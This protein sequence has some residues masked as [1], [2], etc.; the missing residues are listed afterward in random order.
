MKI[1]SKGKID[2]ENDKRVAFTLAEQAVIKK[3]IELNI[4]YLDALNNNEVKSLIAEADKKAAIVS[5]SIWKN[6]LEK[7]VE[8]VKHSSRS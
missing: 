3:I 5:F 6:Y 7:K 1:I 4:A 8:R 2:E